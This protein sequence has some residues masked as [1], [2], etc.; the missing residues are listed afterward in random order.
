MSRFQPGFWHIIDLQE[1]LVLLF[2]WWCFIEG[3][4]KKKRM[5]GRRGSSLVPG[6]RIAPQIPHP[7]PPKSMISSLC[8]GGFA[9]LSSTTWGLGSTVVFIGKNPYISGSLKLK[10]ML[11]KEM[12]VTPV[13]RFIPVFC[14]PWVATCLKVVSRT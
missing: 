1:T 6:S 11:F 12:T 8:I 14:T 13:R 4:T 3:R 5:E 9:S 10:L 2:P 7:R